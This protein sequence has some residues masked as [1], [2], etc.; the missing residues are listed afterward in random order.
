MRLRFVTKIDSRR[1]ERDLKETFM[2][3]L[4]SNKLKT[5]AVSTHIALHMH[6]FGQGFTQLTFALQHCP[7]AD[8][9]AGV[10]SALKNLSD[11]FRSVNFNLNNYTA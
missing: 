1:Y 6:A 4:K 3:L 10:W 9:T 7:E 8:E 11:A 5:E 2:E